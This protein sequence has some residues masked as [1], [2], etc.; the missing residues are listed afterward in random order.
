M[1]A[2]CD[3]RLHPRRAIGPDPEHDL[4]GFGVGSEMVGDQ[5]VQRASHSTSSGN[6]RRASRRPDSSTSSMS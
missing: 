1:V 6:R 5:R 2:G 3:Q 4:V